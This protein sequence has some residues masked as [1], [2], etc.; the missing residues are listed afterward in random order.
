SSS[1]P[2]VLT[3]FFA[4]QISPAPVPFAA[5]GFVVF[6][7]PR[8]PVSPAV[9]AG[10][11]AVESPGFGNRAGGYALPVAPLP[12]LVRCAALRPLHAQPTFPDRVVPFLVSLQTP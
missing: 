1:P 2:G 6:L 5:P 8:R 9:A 3:T 11:S 7:A 10:L 4:G 12:R